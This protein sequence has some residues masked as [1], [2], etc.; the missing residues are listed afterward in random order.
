M[1]ANTKRGSASV[2]KEPEV[3]IEYEGTESFS[4]FVEEVLKEDLCK[5]SKK[6]K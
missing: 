1:A 2:K 5:Q 6:T 4:D 3:I